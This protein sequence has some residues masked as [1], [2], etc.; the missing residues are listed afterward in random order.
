[1][2]K[3]FAAFT[4]AQPDP[5][6]SYTRAGATVT[7]GAVGAAWTRPY[8]GFT[9]DRDSK[10]LAVGARVAGPA[11]ATVG[12]EHL[13]SQ[14]FTNWQLE[15]AIGAGTPTAYSPAREV[16]LT[17]VAD[18][19][20]RV[21]NPR[22]GVDLTTWVAGTNCT[23]VWASTPSFT[24]IPGVMRMIAIGNGASM[25]AGLSPANRVVAKEGDVVTASAGFR[26][27][28]TLR[29]VSMQI[30][31]INSSFGVISTVQGT[32][33][34]EVASDWVRP[35][36]T[37]Q[38]PAGTIGFTYQ[39]YVNTVVLGEEHFVDAVLV[40]K[41]AEVGTYFDGATGDDFIW[42]AAGADAAYSYYYENRLDRAEAIGRAL[43]DSVPM[44]IGVKAAQF[45]VFTG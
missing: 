4:A 7:S 3:D 18:R 45:G 28:T 31:W 1:M 35:S 29:S 21:V 9:P 8:V 6:V 42:G 37:A 39:F 30:Q 26:P 36:V 10:F 2:F 14:Y 32:P 27:N 11:Q 25:V 17:V 43:R 44:G 13:A 19:I 40:E 5:V 34:T 22:M 23:M 33:V 38:A 41:G 20:N 12:S 16:Q 15:T 24:S